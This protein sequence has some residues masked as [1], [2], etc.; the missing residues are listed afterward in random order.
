MRCSLTSYRPSIFTIIALAHEPSPPPGDTPS[1]PPLVEQTPDCHCECEWSFVGVDATECDDPDSSG[2]PWCYTT[3]GAGCR[4]ADN[5][6]ATSSWIE[7]TPSNEPSSHCVSPPPLAPAPSSPPG[8]ADACNFASDGVCDDGGPGAQYG[9]CNLGEDALD[10]GCR[11][12]PPSPPAAVEALSP[13]APPL[14]PSPPP[15][16]PPPRPPPL[17]PSGSDYTI[18]AVAV[19]AGALGFVIAGAILIWWCNVRKQRVK[20]AAAGAGGAGP[21]GHARGGGAVHGTATV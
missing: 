4:M 11:L 13:P 21:R 12:T 15:P 7:C 6:L 9:A 19:G 2:S 5:T 1:L 14:S 18:F 3:T 17:A 20:G 16:R 10:C 8:C